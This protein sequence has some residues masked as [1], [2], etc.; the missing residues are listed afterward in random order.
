MNY[1]DEEQFKQI[2]GFDR[3]EVSSLGRVI[4]IRT[5]R[6][7]VLS[8]TM[9]GIL[10]VG[11]MLNGKQ[12]RRSV[13]VLVARAFVEGETEIMNTPIQLDGDH[14]NLRAD[15][16]A[17]RPRWLALAYTKQFEDPPTWFF[18]APVVETR[19]NRRY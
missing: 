1:N 12:Y 9:D 7:M 18:A 4:N 17:W 15:N 13:K 19:T 11:L 14:K 16:L 10:T 3:Y 2:P 5:G 6:D 8:P